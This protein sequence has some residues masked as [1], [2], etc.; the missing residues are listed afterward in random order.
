MAALV[1]H[2]L[3]PAQLPEQR[4]GPAAYRR[5]ARRLAAA[6]ADPVLLE[7]VARADQLGRTTPDAL[8][9]RFAAGERFL[10]E[11]AAAGVR[12]APPRD[13]V[14]GRHLVAR[15]HAPGPSFAALLAR[16]REIQDETGLEDAERI[17]DRLEQEGSP[18]SGG[19]R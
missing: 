16:C 6:G 10:D 19:T 14:Q 11:A 7:R 1:R 9:G 13:V 12:D 8:A 18:G 4:A 17:L 2:H 5:L 3:A 15:G